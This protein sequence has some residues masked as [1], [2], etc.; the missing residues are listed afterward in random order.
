MDDEN[1]NSV[2]AHGESIE[3]IPSQVNPDLIVVAYFD[4]L[5]PTP[6][7]NLEEETLK[8]PLVPRCLEKAR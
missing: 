6:V 2:S 8:S 1:L 3:K 4:L 7:R 5:P